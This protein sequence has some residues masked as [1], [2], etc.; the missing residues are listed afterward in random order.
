MPEGRVLMFQ[1][2]PAPQGI[3]VAWKGHF[4]GRH[5]CS[6]GAL[7]LQE[8]EQIR[9]QA[10]HPTATITVE[11]VKRITKLQNDMSRFC[12]AIH[13]W[14]TSYPRNQ[15]HDPRAM[16]LLQ[17]IDRLRYSIPLQLNSNEELDRRI[18]E[19]IQHIPQL[20]GQPTLDPL[21]ECLEEL[22]RITQVLINK[23]WEKLKTEAKGA[24][25]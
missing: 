10:G 6:L 24:T 4:Y 1:I 20:T 14:M 16:E 13:S 17:E 3:P 19:L 2:P 23:E 18:K 7:N 11:R 21:Q 25:P 8:I 9:N 15:P 12:G 5:A 22:T